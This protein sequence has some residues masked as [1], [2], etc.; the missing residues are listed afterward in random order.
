V[1]QRGPY[2]GRQNARPLEERLAER[3]KPQPT[4]KCG[5]GA[6][7]G[8]NTSK[9][10]WRVYLSGHYRRPAAYKDPEWL[11]RAYMDQR[12]SAAE[13][14]RPFGVTES[15]IFKF[16]R[17]FGIPMRDA[18]ESHRGVMM[19]SRNP[20]WKGGVAAWP[21]SPDWRVVAREMRESAK[22]TCEWCGL[23]LSRWGTRLHVH[24]ADGNKLN[25][26]RA[27]LAVL[28][29]L[30]HARAHGRQEVTPA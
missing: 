18:S 1:A 5:C 21:Y 28:C 4:C 2:A 13:I 27:N 3:R 14:A 9:C 23:R 15:V 24:H 8:W 11:R 6:L 22:W 17:K 7:V 19:G 30:C 20:A 16:L 25:N 12:Q 26:E 10:R 29:W